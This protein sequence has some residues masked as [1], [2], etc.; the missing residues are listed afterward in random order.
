MADAPPRVK[1][2]PARPADTLAL[3]Q[4]QVGNMLWNIDQRPDIS[5]EEVC[6]AL[7]S[8]AYTLGLTR[9]N[10]WHPRRSNG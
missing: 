10:D 8:V 5:V 1:R 2:K 6:T 4:T 9:E 7:R 3:V